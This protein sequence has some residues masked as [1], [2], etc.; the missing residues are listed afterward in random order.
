MTKT[1]TTQLYLEVFAVSV[2]RYALHRVSNKSSRFGLHATPSTQVY[3]LSLVLTFPLV[4][5]CLQVQQAK[6]T[7]QAG[8]TILVVAIS[9]WVNMMEIHEMATDP[10]SA[11]AFVVDNFDDFAHIVQGLET[12]ICDGV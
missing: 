12:S 3:V 2:W 10:D 5:L 6:L 7:R 11:N 1:Q 9:Q 4:S 8:I